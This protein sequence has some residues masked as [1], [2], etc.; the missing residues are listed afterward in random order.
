MHGSM[1][2]AVQKLQKELF[3]CRSAYAT[4]QR[5]VVQLSGDLKDSKQE[6][7]T[8]KRTLQRQEADTTEF[9]S[10]KLKI[11]ELEGSLLAQQRESK[12]LHSA[13]AVL[14]EEITALRAENAAKSYE[15]S[16]LQQ[17]LALQKTK[18]EEQAT[19]IMVLKNQAAELEDEVAAAENDV[20]AAREALREG[21]RA[22]SQADVT[23]QL[24][25]LHAEKTDLL[26]QLRDV[27]AERD[28]LLSSH[29]RSAAVPEGMHRVMLACLC[30]SKF[31]FKTRALHILDS[32]M[33]CDMQ[34][35]FQLKPG[36]PLCQHP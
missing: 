9:R 20:K 8:L 6:N 11:E 16:S 2:D 36:M 12:L 33:Y 27:K 32:D 15:I 21:D 24:E 30:E 1:D 17:S 23:L 26:K 7:E 10:C 19:Q 5:S 14:D 29:Q 25:R 4:A 34:S 18:V 22:E 13:R 3:A 35:L 28:Q 31:V